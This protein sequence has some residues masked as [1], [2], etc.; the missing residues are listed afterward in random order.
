MIRKA[1]AKRAVCE[2]CGNR[3]RQ[4]DK[5]CRYC[6]APQGEP[7]YIIENFAAIYGPPYCN[8]HKCRECGYTWESSG[9]GSDGEGY[10]PKCGGEAP[11]IW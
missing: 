4:G 7:K 3:Y 9:L 10:C 6:G 1:S 8:E 11:E 2:N 5:Y